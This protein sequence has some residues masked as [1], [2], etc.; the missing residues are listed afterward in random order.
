MNT[1]TYKMTLEI[2]DDIFEVASEFPEK[3]DLE[4]AKQLMEGQLAR[5]V[6]KKYA[7]K[8][9]IKISD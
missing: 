6:I 9:Q 2:N 4:V 3:A 1:K 8:I 5:L 7:D